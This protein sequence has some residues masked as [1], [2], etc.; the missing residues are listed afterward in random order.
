MAALGVMS[1]HSMPNKGSSLS[2]VEDHKF[3]TH[4]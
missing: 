3:I 2:L 1:K 4:G